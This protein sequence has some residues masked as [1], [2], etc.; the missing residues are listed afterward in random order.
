[1]KKTFFN[2]K[3][4]SLMVLIITIVIIVIISTAVILTFT[5][6]NP[7]INAKKAV[8][9][10]DLGVFKSSLNLSVISKFTQIHDEKALASLNAQGDE[11]KEYIPNITEKYYD[12]VK[13]EKGE[14]RVLDTIKEPEKTWVSEIIDSDGAIDE[15]DIVYGTNGN[16]THAISKVNKPILSKGLTPIKFDSITNFVSDTIETDSTWYAYIDQEKEKKENNTSLWANAKSEDGS[17]WVWIPRYAYK[18]SNQG[19]SSASDIDIIFLKGK[20]NTYEDETEKTLDLPEGYV[21]H[22]AFVNESSNG[23]VNGG[24]DS[25][26][27]GIWVAKYEAGFAGVNGI[28]EMPK[29]KQESSVVYTH[30]TNNVYGKVIAGTTPIKYPV[31]K[32]SAYSYN[33][34]NI[35]D[36]YAV[37]R[38]LSEVNNPYGFD[39]SVNS[40]LIKNS[41]W[42]AISYLA[43]SKYGR[44][45]TEISI[46]NVDLNHVS[47]APITI[48]SVT[49]GKNYK[50]NIL[51]S[52]TGNA[53]GVYDLSGGVNE[54]VAGYLN[55]DDGGLLEYGKQMVD[56]NKDGVIDKESN[57]FVSKYSRASKDDYMLNYNEELN[58]QRK[59]EAIWETSAPGKG[60]INSWFSDNSCFA[61]SMFPFL[62]RGNDSSKAVFAGPF[63]FDIS[64]GDPYKLNGFRS[65][66][67][68]K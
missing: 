42:G 57:K 6:N 33:N 28:Y 21:V 36:E 31:F 5:R 58:K 13:I 50:V 49:A 39:E 26:L 53:S 22:P 4:L 40:H 7:I 30:S 67:A 37:C 62:S 45:G 2:K 15:D 11:M 35:G 27:T 9:L 20:T 59:G 23:F 32:P 17:Q 55:N 12:I 18:I 25:E 29:G 10:N 66:L 43:Q 54:S 14:L 34:I 1:M 56:L 41:E 46:N 3:G 60:T 38:K 44:N 61:F 48:S 52:T 16:E 63:C 51:Q 19:T 47:G 64:M 68:P 24:W 8:F 65:V